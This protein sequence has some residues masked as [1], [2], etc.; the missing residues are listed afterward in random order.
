MKRILYSVLL[1]LII[2]SQGCLK[3]EEQCKKTEAPEI[4]IGLLFF[5]SIQINDPGGND[6][7]VDFTDADLNMVYY[8][9][10][11]SGKNNG[12]FTTEFTINE[13][14]T[15]YKES[16]GYWSFRMNN[17]QDYIR[18][19]FFIEGSDIGQSYNVSYDQL[20]AY[21]GGNPHLNFRMVVTADGEFF[22]TESI[23]LSI[24]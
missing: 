12:P 11:C 3:T 21:D 23:V 22:S 9:V 15:L 7:T 2:A 4:N 24:G 5:G 20:K 10:Y 18:V 8:K 1:L 6:I 17:T 16:I 14:G 19:S 13:D